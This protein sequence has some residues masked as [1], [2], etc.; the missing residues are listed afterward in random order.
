MSKPR[1]CPACGQI[2]PVQSGYTYDQELNIRCGKCGKI[3]F[4]ATPTAETELLQ[5]TPSVT[6]RQP[7]VV[8]GGED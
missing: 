8:D 2:L 7:I 4:P 3:V 6:H 1:K 5:K